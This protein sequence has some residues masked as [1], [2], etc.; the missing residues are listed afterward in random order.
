[1]RKINKVFENAN[2][3]EKPMKVGETNMVTATTQMSET[4]T[5]IGGVPIS[6]NDRRSLD[7]GKRV[8]CTI[9][10][11]YV[12]QAEILYELEKNKILILQPAMVQLL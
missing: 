12:K 11:L 7:Y 3:E 8:T 1:M 10:S 6:L 2:Q 5:T 4:L 9:I